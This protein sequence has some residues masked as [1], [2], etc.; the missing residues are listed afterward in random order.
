MCNLALQLLNIQVYGTWA[1]RNEVFP[2]ISVNKGCHS[3]QRLQP[4]WRV[5]EVVSPAGTQEGK[6]TRRPGALRRQLFPTVSPKGSQHVKTQ[7]TGP[8]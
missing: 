3:Q 7:D 6:N 2:A 1:L 4:P 5:S 8:R